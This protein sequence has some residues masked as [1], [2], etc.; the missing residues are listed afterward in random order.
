MILIADSG[1]SK[2][3]WSVID[4][5]KL[6]ASYNSVGLNPYHIYDN[7]IIDV[8]KDL[9]PKEFPVSNISSVF[10]Y[11]AGCKLEPMAQRM[12]SVL[13]QYFTN[14]V[15]HVYSDIVGAARSLF[16]K[17]SGIVAI[18]GTGINTG[19]YSGDTIDNMVPS[20]GYILGDEGSGCYLGKELIR[21]WQYSELPNDILIKLNNFAKVDLSEILRNVY[22]HDNPERFLS[23]FV[24][25][26][27]QNINHT[28]IKTLVDNAFDLFV[29]R[30]L[31]KYPQFK[32]I[33]VG[34]VGS[35]G[36]I[37]A[38]RLKIAIE[39]GGGRADK[40]LQYPIEG[41]IEFHKS[42]N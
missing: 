31:V 36:F 7:G 24:P 13:S 32:H 17:S 9:F 28:S 16:A 26:I 29:E 22:S 37:L 5:S 41:L 11:G 12:E 4:Q 40:F 20:L 25:F 23:G 6:I 27:S 14:S 2:T 42:N 35:V 39:K 15:V 21:A 1:A 38:Q 34:V 18:V 10:F 19:F 3:N 30:H 8:L 33:G